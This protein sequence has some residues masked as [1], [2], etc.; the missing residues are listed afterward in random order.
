M[1]HPRE[2]KKVTPPTAVAEKPT[3]PSAKIEWTRTREQQKMLDDYVSMIH[4]QYT[5]AN[6]D[7]K[8]VAE[9]LDLTIMGTEDLEKFFGYERKTR[10][11]QLYTAIRE[12]AAIGQVP[13]PSVM[14]DTDA[15]GGHRGARDI[16]GVT[17]GMVIWWQLQSGRRRWD[18]VRKQVLPSYLNHGGTPKRA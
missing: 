17:K 18:S 7:P 4:E 12:Y 13:H 10:V 16:R 15:T 6:A 2:G 5:L 14:P 8:L 1:T 9:L 3:T 11:Y